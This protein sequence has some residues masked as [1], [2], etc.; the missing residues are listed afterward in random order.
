V[1]LGHASVDTSGSVYVSLAKRSTPTG[2][3][4]RALSLVVGIAT[5]AVIASAPLAGA[6]PHHVSATA[7]AMPSP[8]AQTDGDA[9]LSRA[10][11]TEKVLTRAT[12]AQ[13]G[14]DLNLPAPTTGSGCAAEGA[15]S[16]PVLKG[17]RVY[18]IANGQ[19]NMYTA[20]TGLL[21]WSATPDPDFATSLLS[22]SVGDGLV[23]VGEL[24]CESQSDPNGNIVAYDST[25]GAQVWSTIAPQDAPCRQTG[26]C[27][28]VGPLDELVES[29]PYLVQTGA[30]PGSGQVTSVYD[31][32]TGNQVWTQPNFNASACGPAVVVHSL[33]I[34]TICDDDTATAPLE[35]DS[36]AT[37]QKVWRRGGTWQILRGSDQ[38]SDGHVY[39]TRTRNIDGD[40]VTTAPRDLD[41]TT[42]APRF[43]LTGSTSILAVDN[44]HV[45]AQCGGSQ[46][47]AFAE[48]TGARQWHIAD[49]SPLAAEAGGALY[50]ADGKVVNTATGHTL[51]ALWQGDA[52]GIAVGNGRVAAAA[53]T[54]QSL[55][56]ALDVYGIVSSCGSS[57]SSTISH[58]NPL[59]RCHPHARPPGFGGGCCSS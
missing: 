19:V 50:L 46:V 12:V 48:I 49:H 18:D 31:V 30:T 36:L 41:A 6:A 3:H 35:A 28:Q 40:L 15:V 7:A 47:C 53:S 8:W 9:A 5:L 20:S 21:R 16:S 43:E 25:T 27:L 38:G 55:P 26:T 42:G 17:G 1:G 23:V 45:Y 2:S 58:A 51:I 4:H 14:L 37:G 11:L 54:G 24:D 56:S 29:G 39:V 34:H 33:V 32:A 13:A 44:Y 22:L 52:T 59:L 57:L 10:N